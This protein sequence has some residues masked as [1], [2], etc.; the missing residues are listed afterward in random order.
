MLHR[1]SQNSN[2]W[3]FV[4]DRLVSG[5][6]QGNNYQRISELLRWV[7]MILGSSNLDQLFL[8]EMTILLLWAFLTSKTLTNRKRKRD[9]WVTLLWRHIYEL[10]P[11]HLEQTP[12]ASEF[13]LRQSP[14]SISSCI[15]AAPHHWNGTPFLL[16]MKNYRIFWFIVCICEKDMMI[17]SLSRNLIIRYCG[18][19]LEVLRFCSE[20]YQVPS[21]ANRSQSEYGK[22]VIIGI[23]DTGV[24]QDIGIGP[25]PIRWEEWLWIRRGFQLLTLQQKAHKSQIWGFL[26]RT[27]ASTSLEVKK[28]YIQGMFVTK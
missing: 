2:L 8:V 15:V 17:L 27:K 5:K 14:I 24:W 25:A 19:F 10:L 12:L 7:W 16:G 22:E 6:M 13:H 1:L 26:R 28:I 23:V 18:H 11:T 4:Q 20:A 3:Q 9:D 21:Q